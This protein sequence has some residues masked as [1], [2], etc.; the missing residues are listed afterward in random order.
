MYVLGCRPPHNP[1]FP[2]QYTKSQNLKAF[3]FKQNTDSMNYLYI[4]VT[5]LFSKYQSQLHNQIVL[6]AVATSR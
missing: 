6:R 4:L 1:P 5:Y 3:E 2:V